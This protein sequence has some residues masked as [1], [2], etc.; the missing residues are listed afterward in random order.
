[1]KLSQLRLPK[2]K[3]KN[4]QKTLMK[5]N[6]FWNN[7]APSETLSREGAAWQEVVAAV[8]FKG[9]ALAGKMCNNLLEKTD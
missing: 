7:S 9:S 5:V 3:K 2:N 4:Q 8:C 6:E 1:M